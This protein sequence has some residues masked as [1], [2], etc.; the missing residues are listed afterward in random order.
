MA[1]SSELTT[2]AQLQQWVDAAHRVV[3]FGGA[4]VSTESGIPDFRSPDGLYNQEYDYPPE[5]ILSRSFFQAHQDVFYRFYRDRVLHP[6]A[7]P[8]A[9]HLALAAMERAGKLTGVVTQNIDGLHQGAGSVNVV[10]L[11]GSIWHNRCTVCGRVFEGLDVVL[12]V[13]EVPRC[14]CG[15]II[16]PGIVMYED[17]LDQQVITDAITLI[18]QADL[19]II[20]G[21]SLVAY[22]AAGLVDYFSGDHIAVIN[23]DGSAPWG[24]REVL[25]ITEPIGTV[26]DRLAIR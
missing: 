17:P 12:G 5:T 15:G 20:G 24:H 26:L 23:R 25:I 11:H 13:D 7:R 22:P 4:G 19:M 2:Q 9:A 6:D 21:T 14:P 8:N 3:F 1:K 16:E 18:S 10:E